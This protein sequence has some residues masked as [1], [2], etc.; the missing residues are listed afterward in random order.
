MLASQLSA[1]EC[2]KVS[3]YG[4]FV[5]QKPVL[6]SVPVPVISTVPPKVTWEF[7]TIFIP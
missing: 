7:R 5:M 3:L 6:I 2:L 4:V 1:V